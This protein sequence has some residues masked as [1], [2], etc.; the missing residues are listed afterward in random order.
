MRQ[1]IEFDAE[2]TTLRGWLYVPD[3]ASGPAPTIVMCHGYS[4]VKEMYLDAF[5]E[6]FCDA[7]FCALV[8]DNRNLGASDGEPRQE[9]DPWAQVRD[10]RRRD[11][12]SPRTLDEVDGDRIGDLGLEL[13]RRARAR[14]GRDRPA[15]EV[16]RRAGAADQR[17]RERAP[18]GPRRPD[19]A[20]AGDVRRRPRGALSRRGAA[21]D[22]GRRA[23]GRAVRDADAD[24]YEWFTSTARARAPAWRQ[25][26]HAAQ[27]RDVLGVRARHV[28][29][30]HLTDAAA[31]GRRARRPPDGLAWRSTATARAA[32]ASEGLPTARRRRN[33]LERSTTARSCDVVC[34]YRWRVYTRCRVMTRTGR[35]SR[36]RNAAC[37]GLMRS[38]AAS[39]ENHS[40]RSTSGN[41]CM[42]PDRGGHCIVNVF[43]RIASASRS[44]SSAHACTTLPDF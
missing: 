10:Y 35:V 19:R 44:P 23:R 25:R 26:V 30:V 41:S 28:P 15:R 18:A 32:D 36:S 42:P 13:Q 29:A 43:E 5:A 8:Y 22:P 38:R 17:P 11:H 20:D 21:D 37:A 4:A 39:S 9:I 31:D 2:G 33:R 12:T 6:V 7:G 27:R 3:S 24:S 40:A 34:P 14:R 16:R 1:D